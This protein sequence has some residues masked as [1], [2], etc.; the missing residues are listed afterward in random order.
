MAA[1]LDLADVLGNVRD[2]QRGRWFDLLDPVNGRPT[3]IKLQIAG[4]DSE[5]QAR[6]QLR[7]ADRLAELADTDG[8]VSAEDR[9]KARIEALATCVLDWAVTENGEELPH[10]FK[11]TVRL[12]KAARWIEEA[13]DRLAGDRSGF[14]GGA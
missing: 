12:L 8:R 2:Q 5:T 14:W 1:N 3:G 11:N 13:A 9:H 6:A 10:N 4:P 7:L